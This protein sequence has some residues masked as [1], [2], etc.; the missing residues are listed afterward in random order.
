[1]QH[2]FKHAPQFGITG[3]W[4][5]QNGEAFAQAIRDH[6]NKSSIE[7]IEGTYRGTIRVTHYFDP[8][9]KLNVMLDQK[10]NLV[11]AWKLTEEQFTYLRKIFNV[12]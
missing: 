1:M 11:G 9:T 7:I 8:T 4:N 12:Q 3:T 6:I 5:K 10:G 2:E